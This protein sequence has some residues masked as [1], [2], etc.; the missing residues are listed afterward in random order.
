M[1]H[2]T[3]RRLLKTAKGEVVPD[4]IIRGG[5][6]VNVFT[7]RVDENVSILIK[8]GY[9]SSIEDGAGQPSNKASRIID[10]DGFYL[11]PGFIDSHTHLDSMQP[12]YGIVPYA[13]RGGT[14]TVVSECAMVAQSCGISA[15]HSFIDSTGA[16]PSDATSSRQG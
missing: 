2:L 6:V 7:N 14:T 1:D 13:I 3:L 11:C 16:T 8:D 15:L 10:A 5:R 9:I 12:F 4:V